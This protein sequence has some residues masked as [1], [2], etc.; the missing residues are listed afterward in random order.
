MPFRYPCLDAKARYIIIVVF[1]SEKDSGVDESEPERQVIISFV[2]TK[3]FLLVAET[4]ERQRQC[5]TIENVSA[6]LIASYWKG[7]QKKRRTK[8]TIYYSSAR[9]IMIT[10]LF[11]QNNTKMFLSC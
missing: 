10:S 11:V 5:V 7:K 2:F 3:E 6:S 8:Y 9:H 4:G 1:R